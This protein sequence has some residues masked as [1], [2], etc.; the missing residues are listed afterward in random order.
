MS[1]LLQPAPMG[2]T[3]GLTGTSIEEK[4]RRLLGWGSGDSHGVMTNPGHTLIGYTPLPASNITNNNS[5]NSAITLTGGGGGP[6]R[7]KKGA[8]RSRKGVTIHSS[9]YSVANSSTQRANVNIISQPSSTS[10]N[11]NLTPPP[12]PAGE[13]TD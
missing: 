6:S 3:T 11:S 13:L 2:T 5:S 1:V 9:P 10:G 8:N 12:S 4:T 7:Q